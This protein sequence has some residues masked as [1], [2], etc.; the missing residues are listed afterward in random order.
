M[1][2]FI[3]F[4]LYLKKYMCTHI[5]MSSIMAHV[6]RLS[7]LKGEVEGL[8]VC[9]QHG[10]HN[11]CEASFGYIMRPCLKISKVKYDAKLL[12]FQHSGDGGRRIRSSRS[13]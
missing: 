9:G 11:E 13:S 12:Q 6:C 10:L 7:T 2:N 8:R 1:Q 4:D 3:F 5:H